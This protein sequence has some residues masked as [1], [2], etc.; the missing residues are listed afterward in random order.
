MVIKIKKSEVSPVTGVQNIQ[1]VTWIIDAMYEGINLTFENFLTD[2]DLDIDNDNDFDAIDAYESYNDTYLIGFIKVDGLWDIDYKAE[3][4]A[5]VGETY[6]QVVH[7]RYVSLAAPCSPCFPYQND[8]DT[9]G[10][11]YTYSL[12]PD[13]YDEYDTPLEII[14]LIE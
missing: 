13:L 9:E 5:I 11:F 10:E 6:I 12:P 1:N 14:E 8:L 4:S 3:Y 7:S 2:N